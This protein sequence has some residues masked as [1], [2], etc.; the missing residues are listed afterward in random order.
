M[1]SLKISRGYC[2]LVSGIREECRPN[3]IIDCELPIPGIYC[4]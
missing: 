2:L 1:V 4:F 3:A